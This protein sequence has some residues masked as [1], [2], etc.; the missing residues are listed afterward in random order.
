MNP[1]KIWCIKPLILCISLLTL[2]SLLSA[3]DLPSTIQNQIMPYSQN[4]YIVLA[5]NKVLQDSEWKKVATALSQTHDQAPII[6]F[7]RHPKET[8]D[9]LQRELPRYVAIVDIP[10]NIGYQYVLELNRMS[11]QVDTDIYPDFLWGIITGYTPQAALKTVKHAHTPFRIQTVL[12]TSSLIQNAKWTNNYAWIDDTQKERWGEKKP[13]DPTPKTYSIP[14]YQ[15]IEKWIE[16]YKN[17]EPDFLL[18]ASH[19]YEEALELPFGQGII[20][21]QNGKIVPYPEPYPNASLYANGKRKVFF[22]VGNC[23]I[24]NVNKTKESMV[25]AWMNEQD[26]A[27]FV[28]YVVTTWFGRAGWG[29]MKYFI[30]DPE[31]YT[32]AEAFFLNQKDMLSIMNKWNKQFHT[33][34]YPF[35]GN[36]MIGDFTGKSL[37]NVMDKIGHHWNRKTVGFLY[38]RDVLAYYGDPKWDVK[39]KKT[40]QANDYQVTTD[41]VDG[42]YVMTIQTGKDFDHSQMQGDKFAQTMV[43]DLP[44][45]YFFP[46]RLKNPQ[47]A[48]GENWNVALDE[49]S[50]LV[51]DTNFLPNSTY[52]IKIEADN[53]IKSN[54]YQPATTHFTTTFSV[55]NRYIVSSS[56]LPF[57]LYTLTGQS[58]SPLQQLSK[59]VYI[60]KCQNRVEKIAVR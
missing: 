11:R 40:D 8:L 29:T 44:F 37:Q 10:Q 56:E 38:D 1:T 55:V 52:T 32:T 20:L 26:V 50:I 46:T 9:Q 2:P 31:R 12:S 23:L 30:T 7:D 14:E 15:I 17:L 28:G 39:L 36:K 33:I 3:I 59:G 22:P 42:Q 4:E 16:L 19:G 5:S 53:L 49:N 43:D 51:Y 35:P 58:I 41:I 24:G 6:P 48:K 13:T 27:N 57:Q 45:S 60:I 21:N 54:T 18:T 47:L 25:V 34:D